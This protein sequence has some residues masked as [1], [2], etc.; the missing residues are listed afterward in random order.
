MRDSGAITVGECWKSAINF[1][2]HFDPFDLFP[3]Y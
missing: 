3:S 1:F 2:G